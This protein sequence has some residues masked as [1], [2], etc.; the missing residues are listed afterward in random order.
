MSL[1]RVG[2]YAEFTYNYDYLKGS[3]P[4]KQ[5]IIINSQL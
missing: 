1:Q 5:I 4:T 2:A 3:L